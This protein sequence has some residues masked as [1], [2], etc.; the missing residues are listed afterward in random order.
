MTTDILAELRRYSS[1]E[2]RIWFLIYR[3]SHSKDDAAQKMSA[4]CWQIADKASQVGSVA[5]MWKL[6]RRSTRKVS[7]FTSQHCSRCPHRRLGWNPL[8]DAEVAH[9]DV[10]RNLG[11]L[12]CK[13][14]NFHTP[15]NSPCGTPWCI[16]WRLHAFLGHWQHNDV[17]RF[18]IAGYWTVA[19]PDW[20]DWQSMSPCRLKVM[21]SATT[22]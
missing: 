5:A 8:E 18:L 21:M 20:V 3:R 12:F 17:D 2:K 4:V 6:H 1:G 22:M 15:G 11:S 13:P 10:D 7:N 14:P 9:F 19:S 16:S